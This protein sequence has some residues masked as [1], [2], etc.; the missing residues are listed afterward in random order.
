MDIRT[1]ISP[2][3]SDEA[4]LEEFIESLEDLAPAV[5]EDIAHL[6]NTTYD[7]EAISRLF[8]S[9]HNI[10]GDGALCKV[11]LAVAIAHPI[12]TV[13]AKLRSGEITLGDML[14]ELILLAI[15]RL[16]LA[17][18]GLLHKKPLESLRLLSLIQG[19]EKLADASAA[20]IDQVAKDTIEAV[21][22]F[23]PSSNMKDVLAEEPSTQSS[24]HSPAQSQQDDLRFFRSLAEQLEARS[25]LFKGRTQ[26]LLRLALETNRVSGSPV[27]PS[28]LEAAVYM[29]DI[30]M[31]FLAES[32]WLKPTQLNPI[33]RL[34]LRK[35][36]NYARQLLIRMPGWEEA[37]QIVGQH[38][39]MQDGGGYPDALT[40]QKICT[41][42]KLLA[43]VDAFESIM[44]K[45]SHRGKN[46]SVLRA[47]AE[48][49]ACNNQFAP[50]WIGAFNKIIRKTLET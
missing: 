1:I 20:E 45:H 23:A 18:E 12:E 6:R 48:I 33:E 26:R 32:S 39:E 25:P 22:G 16:E 8:R 10:K 37:A 47:I 43:I 49:N 46:K 17:V 14:A 13:L 7:R 3:I 21:T 38:H 24:T 29:H 34:E 36:P 11:D 28:Q 2:M 31:M 15:D 40:D 5:E 4:A 35:H 19:L 41:G 30:G 42:A 27:P 50:E 44:L 9:V